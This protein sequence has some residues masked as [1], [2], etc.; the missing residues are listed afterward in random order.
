M[1]ANGI[2]RSV[3][4]KSRISVHK[5]RMKSIFFAVEALLNGG[6]LTCAG[7]GRAAQRK[8]KPKHNIKRIDRLMG[9]TKL[10]RELRLFFKAITNIV[11]REVLFPQGDNLI[12]KRVFSLWGLL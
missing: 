10:H 12:P 1:R 4:R 7:L 11:N 6:R 2:L 8:V 5:S 3:L 9:N